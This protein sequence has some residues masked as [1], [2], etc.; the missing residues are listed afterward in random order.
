MWRSKRSEIVFR[1]MDISTW[2]TP[3]WELSQ[4]AD[5]F[6]R[7]RLLPAGLSGSLTSWESRINYNRGMTFIPLFLFTGT[8]MKALRSLTICLAVVITSARLCA[9]V[10]EPAV[11]DFERISWGMKQPDI[12]FVLGSTF[13]EVE[14]K[15][16]SGTT[17]NKV[18][19]FLRT[20]RV[21]A[22]GDQSTVLTA[23]FDKHD[24]T[25][26]GMTFTGIEFPTFL[27]GETGKVQKIQ[28]AFLERMKHYTPHKSLDS[29]G[30]VERVWVLPKTRIRLVKLLEPIT[31]VTI[32]YSSKSYVDSV[33]RKK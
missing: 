15:N 17:M 6:Q 30:V 32:F 11:F 3:P 12:E 1:P 33:G 28:E 26:Y 22:I 10:V 31:S 16:V 8:C 20:T 18:T 7:G 13:G 27:G 25:L 4:N 5:P 23:S 21:T 24:S 29:S 2:K 19:H 14:M 9:Q